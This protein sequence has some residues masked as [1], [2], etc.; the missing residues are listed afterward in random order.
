MLRNPA[1]EPLGEGPQ[2]SY[3]FSP[4]DE[5]LASEHTLAV[6]E[7]GRTCGPQADPRQLNCGLALLSGEGNKEVWTVPGVVESGREGHCHWSTDGQILFAG[8]WFDSSRHIARAT[9]QAYQELLD[10]IQQRGFPNIL[11]VW[12]Y[13][14]AINQP[15][16]D[17][18]NTGPDSERYRQF[19]IGRQRAFD[20]AGF[21]PSAYPAACAIGHHADQAVVY[22]IATTATP[23]HYENPQQLSAYHYP[24]D[25]GP[26]SP[27][28]ARASE[29]A[30]E[31]LYI[32]GTASIVG[33]QS[34][35]MGDLAGQ[36][37]V[38]AENL[39]S[40]CD[41]ITTRS[42]RN[43]SPAPSLLKAYL[44]N[45][46]QLGVVEKFLA[47]HFNDCPAVIVQGDICRQELLVEIDAIF[48][49]TG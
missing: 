49:A 46:E 22:L 34:L 7:F 3:S 41:H 4:T 45:P 21:E 40:L 44:R 43:H 47:N 26:S 2:C 39:K 29:Y 12:N 25:Y 32:S 19:C 1:S 20:L 37:T 18:K 11:R 42:G 30:G 35:H 13:F 6:V 27:S 31:T 38:T 36:L 23:V 10:F 5:L 17:S 48:T 24:D 15:C 14:P 9:E 8:I 16:P 28:F 33:H